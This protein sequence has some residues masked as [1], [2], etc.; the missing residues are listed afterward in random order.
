MEWKQ[1]MTEEE[2]KKWLL[3][4]LDEDMDERGDM[5]LQWEKNHKKE[6]EKLSGTER[7]KISMV[8]SKTNLSLEELDKMRVEDMMALYNQ[9]ERK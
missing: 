8:I 4:E 7:L 6:M 5:L 9:L 3:E 1:N 2:K